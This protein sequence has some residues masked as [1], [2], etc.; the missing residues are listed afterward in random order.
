MSDYSKYKKSG[1]YPTIPPEKIISW[2]KDN[3]EY[4]TRKNDEE[5]IIN[6]PFNGDAGYHFN[7]N[8]YKGTCHDWRSDEW[9]GPINPETNRRN[10]SFIKFVR[11]YKKCGYTAAVSEI[12]GTA[13]DIRYYLKPENRLTDVAAKNKLAVSLPSGVES[14]IKSED[15]QAKI[16]IKWLKS[17]G[18][19]TESIAKNDLKHLGMDVYWPYYEFDTLAYWQSR[20]RLNKKFNFPS[21]DVYDDKGN[22]VGKTDGT[23]GDFLYGFDEIESASYIIITEAIF[24]QHTLGE[25]ALASGG[26]ALTSKQINKIKI[27]GPKK[28]IILSPDNDSAG[29]KSIISNYS[30][31]EPYG[32]KL[33]YSI[34]PELKYEV[35][36][37]KKVTKDW[38]ELGQFVVGFDKVRKIHDKNIKKLNEQTLVEL[39]L[40]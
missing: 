26:A 14:L 10:C 22:K 20:S 1:S 3:F 17:R 28:G 30:L 12:L 36:G 6:N 9:A 32:F 11:L 13:V 18:Y 19:T 25:Q 16:L 21:L 34:P 27:I 38:N 35:D 15:S 39:G 40:R 5:Y 4:K 33:F 7:I 2:I 24:D 23:K 8:P 31:L 37:V 29:V